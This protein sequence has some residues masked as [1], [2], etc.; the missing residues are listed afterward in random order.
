MLHTV[1]HKNSTMKN[2]NTVKTRS[3]TVRQQGMLVQNTSIIH[4]AISKAI[5]IQSTNCKNERRKSMDKR[6][7]VDEFY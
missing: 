2:R 6:R 4:Q 1:K 5:Q 7:E 3:K